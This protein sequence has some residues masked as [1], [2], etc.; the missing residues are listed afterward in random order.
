MPE[1][2]LHRALRDQEMI[3]VGGVGGVGK[4][5]LSAAIAVQAALAG[6]RVAV[7]TIDEPRLPAETGNTDS[8]HNGASD[9]E[10]ES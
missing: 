7:L 4:T 10:P 3:V 8:S 6:R 1:S 2:A 5:T 9:D